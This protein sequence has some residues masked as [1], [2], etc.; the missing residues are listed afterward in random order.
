MWDRYARI[1]GVWIEDREKERVDTAERGG[2]YR[3]DG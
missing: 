1:E 2:V 3:C